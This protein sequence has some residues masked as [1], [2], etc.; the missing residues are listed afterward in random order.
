MELVGLEP[1]TFCLQNK[2]SPNWATA[3]Y[4]Q[5]LSY[6]LNIF[7]KPTGFATEVLILVERV[8]LSLL[9]YKARVLPLN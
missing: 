5:Y 2:C 6:N 8:E 4:T 9:G 3:P 7:V 1:T